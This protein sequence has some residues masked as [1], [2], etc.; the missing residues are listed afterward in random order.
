MWK[1]HWL[2]RHC[3]K[4][5]IKE[6]IFNKT[7]AIIKI[8]QISKYYYLEGH[9]EDD[10]FLSCKEESEIFST[11][12]DF[13]NFKGANLL[14]GIKIPFSIQIPQGIQPSI[15][16]YKYE[17]KN[18]SVLYFISFELPGINAKRASIIIIKGDKTYSLENYLL[19]EPLKKFEDFYIKPYGD[20]KGGKVSCL[21]KIPKNCFNY[22]EPIPFEFYL[23]FSEYIMEIETIRISINSV[24][25]FNQKDNHNKKLYS[26]TN[27]ELI[28][29]EISIDSIFDKFQIKESFLLP[30]E[31][32][33]KNKYLYLDSLKEIEIDTKLFKYQKLIPICMGG[34]STYFLWILYYIL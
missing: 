3:T 13:N 22:F 1:S 15:Y 27:L 16:D 33:L 7:T 30:K 21:L 29:K 19:N 5:K 6:A 8:F 14:L 10:L 32:L 28:S 2:F 24:V 31:N 20:R 12:I 25:D 17:D 9:L 4:K 11:N 26:Y 18:F 23:D 34:L